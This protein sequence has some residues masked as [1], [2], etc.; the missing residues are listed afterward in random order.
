MEETMKSKVNFIKHKTLS[1]F[2]PTSNF[3]E[4]NLTQKDNNYIKNNENS[5]LK[6]ID[7]FCGCG[8]LS[9]GFEDAGFKIITGNDNDKNMIESFKLNHPNSKSI[10]GDITKITSN[11]LLNN[12]NKEEISLVIGGPPCQG[13]STVGDRRAEDPRNK[14]FYEF[15]RVVKDIK[16]K[17]FVMENVPGI[18]TMQG[19]KVKDTIIEEFE[20]LGYIINI[21]ILN[22]EEFG[23]PQKRRRVF[24]VGN[25][26]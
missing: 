26:F 4:N 15:V 23:V 11:E 7:L 2:I 3:N 20:R 14:L 6:V 22:S 1:E 19:G 12:Y 18:L 24:F 5:N 17:V 13:F 8:G 9:E 21:K 10:L 16:P 25:L